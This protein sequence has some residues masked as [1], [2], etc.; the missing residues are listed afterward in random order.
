[1]FTQIFANLV[2]QEIS[3]LGNCFMYG[4]PNINGYSSKITNMRCKQPWQCNRLRLGNIIHKVWTNFDQFLITTGAL[5]ISYCDILAPAVYVIY[6]YYSVAHSLMP[7]SQCWGSLGYQF[8]FHVVENIESGIN[9]PR[10]TIRNQ[11]SHR[12]RFLTGF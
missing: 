5:P 2:L 1:M 11:W 4:V 10:K 12:E 3:S 9:P 6:I 7:R 8:Y